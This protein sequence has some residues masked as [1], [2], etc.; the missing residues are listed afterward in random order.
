MKMASLA[1]TTQLTRT[2]LKWAGIAFAAFLI[3][4]LVL[5]PV[6]KSIWN[7]VFPK[8]HPAPTTAFGKLPEI[9][10]PTKTQPTQLTFTIQTTAG[11]LPPTCVLEVCLV[12][13]DPSQPLNI[14][15]RINVYPTDERAAGFSS[16]D[17]A[18]QKVGRIDFTGEGAAVSPIIYSWRDAKVEGR[19]I[20]FDI[21]TNAFTLKSPIAPESQALP[22]IEATTVSKRMLSDMGLLPTDLEDAK[23]KTI[24]L[25]LQNG[26]LVRTTSLAESNAI[27]VDFYRESLDKLPILYPQ[28]DR[29]LMSFRVK[30]GNGVPQQIIEANFSHKPVDVT[31]PSTYPIK[32]A[33]QAFDELQAG[34]GYF[35]ATG[36]S[37]VFPI[38][39]V[40]LAYYEGLDNIEFF[41]P[42]FV[43]EGNSFQAFVEA[44]A[45]EWQE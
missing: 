17:L 45:P 37:K 38:Q 29:S 15:D 19:Q 43:F 11:V 30:R 5:F 26:N 9:P 40:Y 7:A 24:F 4:R 22:L 2:A 27:Q 12:S 31:N 21:V 28:T 39:K 14:P 18:K 3:I 13:D 25:K 8:A 42:V 6:G 36:P 23:T 20:T 1:Q 34:K 41:L 35:A 10:F 33:Q 44:I 32:T 16:Y